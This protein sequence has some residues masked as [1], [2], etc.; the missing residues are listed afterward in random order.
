MNYDTDLRMAIAYLSDLEVEL[1]ERSTLGDARLRSAAREDMRYQLDQTQ[2]LVAALE[3][4]AP[5]ISGM[6]N[7]GLVDLQGMRTWCRVVE[8]RMARICCEDGTSAAIRME[9]AGAVDLDCSR[10]HAI[11]A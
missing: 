2:R 6:G 4:E 3:R 5:D 9:K 7:R 8:A 1:E 10:N 11:L